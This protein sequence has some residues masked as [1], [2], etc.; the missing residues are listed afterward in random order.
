[1][2]DDDRRRYL[3]GLIEDSVAKYLSGAKGLK[4][5]AADLDSLTE[6]LKEVSDPR[7]AEEL[8]TCWG[9]IEIVNAVN[10]EANRDSL[11]SDQDRRIH[12]AIDELLAHIRIWS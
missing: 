12:E 11:T 4:E 5:L 10:L 7:W 2:T 6:S 1:M 9:E 8:R 3:V